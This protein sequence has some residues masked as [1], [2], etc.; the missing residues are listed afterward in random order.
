MNNMRVIE[1]YGCSYLS[2]PGIK[3]IDSL[4]A[5]IP[6]LATGIIVVAKK[7]KINDE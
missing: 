7:E 1:S 4:I 3:Y 2:K 6:T 5:H